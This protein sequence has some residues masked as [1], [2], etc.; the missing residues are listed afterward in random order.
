MGLPSDSIQALIE[1]HPLQRQQP[2]KMSLGM[3]YPLCFVAAIIGVLSHLFI[4]IR[5]EWHLQAPT[6]V[7]FYLSLVLVSAFAGYRLEADTGMTFTAISL[8]GGSYAAALFTSI[9]IYRKLFHRL[10]NFPGPWAAGLTK[11]W[12][13]W[14]CRSGKNH[15]VIEKLRMRYGSIIRT[16]PEELT[17]IDPAVPPAVDGPGNCCTKAVWYDFLLPEIALNTTRSLQD[18]DA[19]RRIWDRGF[20]TTALDTYEGRVIQYAELL[21]MRIDELAQNGSAVNVSDWFYWFTFD[22]MGEFAFAKS[23]NMLQDEKWHFSVT[24]LRKAMSLLG[25]FSPVPWIAQIAFYITPW[26]YIVRDWLGMM[27]WC[28]ARMTERIEVGLAQLLQL[29]TLDG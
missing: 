21:A 18:H 1:P 19:R 9:A 3:L 6:L 5:G 23:F 27:D 11:F 26:M 25:P 20:S 7:K 4:F 15:L 16:G 2:Y 8:I 22:V 28:K 24:L 14:Q 13:V 12:H 17:I 29:L 10:H